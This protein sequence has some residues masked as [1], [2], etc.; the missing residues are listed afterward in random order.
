M[1][2]PILILIVL[3]AI[4][5]LAL[6]V[7]RLGFRLKKLILKLPLVDAE[8]ERQPSD[9]AQAPAPAVASSAIDQQATQG[10]V[11][12]RSPIRAPA[13][14]GAQVTQRADG[15]KSRIDDSGITLE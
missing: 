1:S 12:R 3:V 10:G 6:I 7:Y 5:A 9:A 15:D 8:M 13:D 4:I 2:D 14:S 11:I